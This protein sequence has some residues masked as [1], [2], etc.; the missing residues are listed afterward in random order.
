MSVQRPLIT[1]F[2]AGEVGSKFYG[3]FDL[4]VYRRGLT[5]LENWV[6]F[7]QGGITTRPPTKH[8]GETQ[9]NVQARYIPFVVG[10]SAFEVELT[11]LKIRV[12]QGDTLLTITPTNPI[13]TTYTLAHIPDIRYTKINNALYLVHPSYPIAVL[14]WGGA[15]AFSLAN[16]TIVFG[17][18]VDAWQA[19]HAY[20]EGEVITNGTPSKTYICITAGT[21]AAATG[22]TTEAD[23]ITDGTAHW[24]WQFTKPFSQAGDYPSSVVYFNGRVWFAGAANHP[25]TAWASMPYEF[26]RFDFFS[27]YTYTGVELVPAASWVDPEVPETQTVTYT[28]TVIGDGNAIEFALASEND[29]TIYWMCAADH[30][31]IGTGTSEWVATKEITATNVE[32][33]VHIRSRMGGPYQQA[34]VVGQHPLFLQGTSTKAFLWEYAYNAENAELNST[35]LTY[36]AEHMLAAGCTQMDFVAMPQPMWLGVTNG[37]LACLLYSPKYGVAAW[38]WIVTDGTIQSMCVVPGTT[39]DD[40]YIEVLRNSRYCFERLEGLW[41]TGLQMVDSYYYVASAV[42]PTTGLARF[43]GETVWIYDVTAGTWRTGAVSG[44][45]VATA[46][47]VGHPM[48]LGLPYTC[49]LQSLPLQTSMQSGA[50]GQSHLKRIMAV[51]A[52]VLSS[53]PFK[54]S[55]SQTLNLEAANYAGDAAWTAEY[56][57]DV[58]IP[59][60]SQW[61]KEGYLWI[62]QDLRQKTTILALL[63]EVDE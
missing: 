22:P 49:S 6:P 26:G 19:L 7:T 9:G 59:F 48:W 43:N 44:G 13:T 60:Q 40:I 53:F 32:E 33:C 50:S 11:A 30:L 24:S 56:S 42:N 61:S 29:E 35:D 21:S 3:R 54:A 14:T 58:R 1:D 46:A 10:S 16:L 63:P 23:D 37:K 4:D 38:F 45:S 8:L 62:V 51:S 17:T 41:E 28:Q 5:K 31:L 12:W 57:G 18:D 25:D 2:S 52:R 39:D 55:Y 27:I 36:L 47:E 15:S 34:L 20:A